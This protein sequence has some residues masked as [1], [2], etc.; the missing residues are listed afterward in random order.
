MPV[1][2][3][4]YAVPM[5]WGPWVD[6]VGNFGGRKYAIKFSGVARTPSPFSV[7]L[8]YWDGATKKNPVV[9]G[10]GAFTIKVDCACSVRARFKSAGTGQAIQV[11][12][13]T[14]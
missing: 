6:L 13:D 14:P 3:D 11:R 4:A 2:V 5:M 10:P 1:R 12:I 7:E 8:D 9:L